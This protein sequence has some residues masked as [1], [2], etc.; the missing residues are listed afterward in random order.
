MGD[1]ARLFGH[2]Q[3]KVVILRA[4][5]G[6]VQRA[7][8][9]QQR[10]AE[11]GKM[12][13]IIVYAQGI[14]RV[15]GLQMR[16]TRVLRGDPKDRFIGIH[17]IGVL[18]TDGPHH[19][20][21]RSG[22]K[23]IIMI[24]E[25]DIIARNHFQAGVGIGGDAPVFRQPA[26]TDAGILRGKSPAN[27]FRL[28]VLPI[29]AVGQAELPVRVGLLPHRLDHLPQKLR[30]R[31][32]Q[33]RCNADLDPPGEGFRPLGLQ[34][35]R[36]KKAWGRRFA[37]LCRP[38]L[39]HGRMPQPGGCPAQRPGHPPECGIADSVV[40]RAALG[41]RLL[42][43]FYVYML[44]ADGLF[45]FAQQRIPIPHAAFSPFYYPCSRLRSRARKPW[46]GQGGGASISRICQPTQF[47]TVVSPY[48]ICRG[49]LWP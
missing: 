15:I 27:R 44:S 9:L 19:L 36:R 21:Q 14:R 35:L 29:A 25:A 37:M 26:V 40:I 10:A 28:S 7:R 5:T 31:V 12:A 45:P 8:R 17:K 34:L 30:R 20:M 13:D 47:I 49:R 43:R 23:Q 39:F 46:G 11:H 38:A 32:V 33:R 4:V 16:Y 22:V 42:Q 48:W 2:A 24:Q 18:I 41:Q 3:K 1:P 6:R